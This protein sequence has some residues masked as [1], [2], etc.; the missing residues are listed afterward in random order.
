LSKVVVFGATGYTGGNISSEL[1]ARGHEVIGVARNVAGKEIAGA[2][3]VPGDIADTA[4]LDSIIAGANTLV[5]AIRHGEPKVSELIP[6]IAAAAKSAG[7]RIGVVGG[8]GS[9]FTT[10]GGPRVFETAEFPDAY[11]HEAHAAFDTLNALQGADCDWFYVSPA[12]VY[13]SYA[14]GERIGAYRLG[15]DIV[16]KDADGKSFISGEDF[17]TAFVDEIEAKGHINQRFTVGY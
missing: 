14:P 3:L 10:D 12:Q 2:T 15:G 1:V 7:A 6:A 5:L 17:A 11:K 16:V 9:L 13:G 8:A 4:A